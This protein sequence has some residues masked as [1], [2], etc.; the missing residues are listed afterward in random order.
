MKLREYQ[1]EIIEETKDVYQFYDPKSLV[2]ELATGGGKS[3]IISELAKHFSDNESHVVILVSITELI[4]QLSSHLDQFGVSH[5]VVKAGKDNLRDDDKMVHIIMA[6]TAYSRIDTLNF[7]CDY[8][9]QDE[10]HIRYDS[11][12]TK[13]LLEHFKPKSRIGLSATPYDSKGYK[14]EGATYLERFGSVKNLTKQ[15]YLTPIK[16]LVSSSSLK[17]DY[18]SISTQTGDYNSSE[19]EEIISKEKFVNDAINAMNSIG[20]KD[21]KTIVF[22]SSI[23]QVELFTKLLRDDGY[24]AYSYHSKT[25]KREAERL[26]EAFKNNSEYIEQDSEKSLFNEAV[27]SHVKCLVSVNKLAIGFDVADIELGVMARPT[28]VRSLYIQCVGRLTRLHENKKEA[29]L[30][31]VAQCV[32]EHGMY[33][34]EYIPKEYGK[35]SHSTNSEPLSNVQVLDDGSNKTFEVTR[36]KYEVKVKELTSKEDYSSMTINEMIDAMLLCNSNQCEKM[37]KLCANIF[38]AIHGDPYTNTNGKQ[39]TL[40]K[41]LYATDWILED[42]NRATE[43]YPEKKEHWFK[44]YK[45]RMRN[46]IK[47]GANLYSLKFFIDMLVEDY[48]EDLRYKEQMEQYQSQEQITQPDIE[49]DD[50]EIPF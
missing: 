42:Y 21:K 18:S 43:K 4:N 38:F 5:S 14:L 47:T 28:K 32:K 46:I 19:L 22:C 37:F 9:I 29:I 15:G 6:Q 7:E 2:I 12:Q 40:D 16:T 41:I 23:E 39:V 11:K 1:K 8:I 17:H 13:T 24:K 30:L 31:D 10:V 44:A 45:T 35:E 33:D 50:D 25:D 3:L 36:Q 20:A 48:E 26:L 27:K 49:I 34:D